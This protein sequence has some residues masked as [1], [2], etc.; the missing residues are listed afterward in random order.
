MGNVHTLVRSL[1]GFS[2]NDEVIKAVR[3][4]L[5]KPVA[6][7]RRKI[8]M[9]ALSTL[10]HSGGLGAWVAGTKITASVEFKARVVAIRLRGGRNSVADLR[11][12]KSGTKSDIRAIDR[13]R[14]RHPAWGR[15]WR[16]QWFTQTVTPG[17]FTKTAESAPEWSAAIERGV[18]VATGKIHG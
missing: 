4:E 7:V 11:G 13:G 15:R 9:A 2:R 5:R 16:G 12:G 14:V 1:R 10:P 18:A 17:F 3:A 6:P 8:K